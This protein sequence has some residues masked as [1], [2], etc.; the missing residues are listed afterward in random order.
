MSKIYYKLL[1]CDNRL[2]MPLLDVAALSS[3][4][5]LAFSLRL[6]EWW[7]SELGESWWLFP[8]VPLLAIPVFSYFGLYRTMLRYAGSKAFVEMAKAV[9]LQALLLMGLVL[10]I[11]G[12]G[13]TP[14]SIFPIYWFTS[15][16]MI[17]G[18]RFLVQAVVRTALKNRRSPV[19]VIV[20][21][22][23][24]A[25]AELVQA[26]QAGWETEVVAFIDDKRSFQGKEL[27]GLKVYPRSSL[28][29]LIRRYG[30]SQVLLA[31][32][33][34]S[35]ARRREVLALL[36]RCPVA[37]KTVPSLHELVWERA[38]VEQIRDVDIEDLLGREPV[39]PNEALMAACVRG[40]SVMITG[41]GGS[42]GSELARQIFILN[43]QRLILYE[44]SEFSLYQVER[45]LRKF[46]S[47]HL[48]NVPAT[49]IVPV[50]GSVVDRS[51]LKN[52]FDA[53]DI[54]T[55]YH[56]AAYKHVP[57]VEQNPA[58]GVFNNVF[59]TLYTARAALAAKVNTFI[60]ISTDKAV[61][62]ANIMGASKRMAE[63]VL[64]G[65]AQHETVMQGLAAC[66]QTT[67]FGI[68]RFGNVLGSS[69]SVVPLFREQI[70]AGGPVTVTHR[71]VI[72]YF[73]TIPEAA[74]LVIQAGSM[75]QGGDVFVLDMGEP[76]CIYDLARRMIALSGLTLRDENNPD[77]DIEI[78]ITGLRPGE[79]LYEEL[80]IGCEVST[81][82]HPRILRAHEAMLP[83]SELIATLE[84][85]EQAC[86]K[87]D[88]A[89]L[90]TLLRQAVN[91]YEP[92]CGIKDPVWIALSEK[93]K[94]GR[95]LAT[96]SIAG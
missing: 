82:Q 48:Q 11:P 12:G 36:E 34:A 13:D 64:Q 52:V 67:R 93:R 27:L 7:P 22:A 72:R 24:S 6:G 38:S 79:K 35:M 73:M 8:V 43:P 53:F 2:V 95:G 18:S 41:A 91:G 70:R 90:L 71:E 58:A 57:L 40:K 85:L 96:H 83:W 54:E 86:K 87:R 44:S 68:V 16:V 77:G 1:R 74:Q 23:G 78:Q 76:V 88:V 51:A 89:S 3:A 84:Q 92:Q 28:K 75:A 9:S 14:R 80:L 60:L 29:R 56:A 10:M 49:E 47:V 25:G 42:I 30:V 45:E 65:L 17:I 31:I 66:Y 15:L 62:P 55:V 5:L 69:G 19:R 21:G 61:R 20:F 81:T 46:Q 26:L 39:T 63:L 32:P 94:A 4:L 50:L 59:G 33:S 37:V